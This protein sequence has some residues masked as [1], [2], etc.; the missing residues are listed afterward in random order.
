[1]TTKAKRRLSDFNFEADGSHV[2]LVHQMQGGGANGWTTLVTKA[3][4]DVSVDEIEKASEVTVTMNIVDFLVKF[5]DLWYDDALVL[6][7]TFGYDVGDAGYS[8]EDSAEFY[9]D[10]LQDR[11]DAINVMKSVVLDKSI[12][13]IKKSIADLSSEDYLKIIKAQEVFEKNLEEAVVKATSIK[14]SSGNNA[15]GVTVTKGTSVSKGTISPSV[16]IKQE[17]DS[18]SEFISKAALDT[19]VQEAV[20]KAVGE[21]QAE[22]TKAQEVIK[23]FEDEKVEAVAKA[24]QARIAEV[25]KDEEAAKELYKGLEGVSEEAF[26]V[27]MKALKKKEEVL[28]QADL[29]KELGGN[30]RVIHQDKEPQ[31]DKTAELLKA[32]FDKGAK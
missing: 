17:E 10:Y 13:E 2:A 12:D 6:A 26:E 31:V 22:L 27:V 23:Q 32:Q 7:M 14:E 15:E 5:F 1:M 28:D 25:E 24:R 3:T 20:T 9:S 8:F 21:V 16:D 30:A 19:L 4:D 29:T 18:M 11:V